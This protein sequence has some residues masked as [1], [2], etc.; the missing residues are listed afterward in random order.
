MDKNG[1]KRVVTFG[2]DAV[3]NFSQKACLSSPVKIVWEGSQAITSETQDQSLT[4]SYSF[5]FHPIFR[6]IL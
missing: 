3:S 4:S 2:Q 6:P 5:Q 1:G